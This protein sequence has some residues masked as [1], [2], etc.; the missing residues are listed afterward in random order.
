MAKRHWLFSN[1]EKGSPVMFPDYKLLKKEKVYVCKKCGFTSP[2]RFGVLMH[3]I[4]MH[5]EL[6]NEYVTEMKIAEGEKSVVS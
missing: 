3:I 2:K 5:P 4:K 6:L 1:L